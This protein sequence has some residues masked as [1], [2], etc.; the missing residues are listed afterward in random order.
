MLVKKCLAIQF[1]N[2]ELFAGFFKQLS[3]LYLTILLFGF[4]YLNELYI[5]IIISRIC[6][7]SITTKLYPEHETLYVKQKTVLKTYNS[8]KSLFLSLILKT[9]LKRSTYCCI[10]QAFDEIEETHGTEPRTRRK[11]DE[12]FCVFFTVLEK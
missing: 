12:V 2:I 9:I 8:V 11:Y 6:K 4:G 7:V 3:Q 10:Y 1:A 5:T